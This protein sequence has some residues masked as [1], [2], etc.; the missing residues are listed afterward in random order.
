MELMS[1]LHNHTDLL[2]HF[3]I[4]ELEHTWRVKFL[5]SK[6]V[7]HKNKK[8]VDQIQVIIDMKGCKL[9]DLTNKQMI[10]VY[11]QLTLEVQRFFPELVHK[12][13]VL[14]SPMFFENVWESELCQCV[15]EETLNKILINSSGTS[16]ELQEEID[17]EELPA[18][19]GGS[20]ECQATCIYSEKGPWSDCENLIN[21]KEPNK[22]VNTLDTGELNED[23]NIGELNNLLFG[24]KKPK[25]N[26]QEE[27]KMLEDDDE[28]QIDLLAQKENSQ[29]LNEF[30]EQNEQLEDLKN[31]IRLNVPGMMNCV[32]GNP[33][34]GHSATNNN[35]EVGDT[36]ASEQQAYQLAQ[37]QQ[38]SSQIKHQINFK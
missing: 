22:K 34:I 1:V 38:Y 33:Q 15:D 30:Y 17:E 8:D 19:Y 21:F 2:V 18:I 16:D 37:I 3:F 28:D 9:K 4:K 29:N 10:Q 26:Q 13:H 12:I 14:N 11:K 32:P 36:E 5:E 35:T 6:E 7:Y 20:C 24:G 23:P 27:F 31:Q 25:N